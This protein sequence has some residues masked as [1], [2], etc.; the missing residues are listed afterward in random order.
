MLESFILDNQVI[1]V[2]NDLSVFK[3]KLL[4]TCIK[5]INPIVRKYKIL[6]MF[7]PICVYV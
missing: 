7:I 4:K 6:L 2:E 1:T 3:F 5:Y